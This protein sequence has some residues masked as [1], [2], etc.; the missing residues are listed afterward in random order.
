[1]SL[2]YFAHSDNL[3]IFCILMKAN[4]LIM[5]VCYIAHLIDPIKV[6]QVFEK[7]S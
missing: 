5:C 7:E 1:M 3:F 4:M 2:Q 6:A